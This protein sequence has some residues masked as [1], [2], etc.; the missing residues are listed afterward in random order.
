MSL[1]E[2]MTGIQAG[3]KSATSVLK[4]VSASLGAKRELPV[5]RLVDALM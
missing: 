1:T 3:T 4:S 5:T 2:I